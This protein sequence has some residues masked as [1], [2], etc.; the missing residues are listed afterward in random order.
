MKIDIIRQ[1]Y[2]KATFGTFLL[3][4]ELMGFTLEREWQYNT[5][6]ISCIPAGEYI[7]RRVNSPRFGPTFEVMDVQDRTDILFH[8]G[9]TVDD[10]MGCILLGQKIGMLNRKRAVLFSKAMFTVFMK[11]LEGLYAPELRITELKPFSFSSET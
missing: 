8:W 4:G 6:N 7:C 9:N 1:D 5:K 10:T 3:N 2:N 11:K